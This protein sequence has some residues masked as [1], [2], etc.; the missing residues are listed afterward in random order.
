MLYSTIPE[1]F[2]SVC[3]RF[4][5]EADKVAYASKV[6]GE[7]KQLSHRQLRDAVECLAVGLLDAG[8]KPGDRVGIVSE[9]RPEWVVTDFA[10]T[11]IGVIDVPVFTSLT[12]DQLA[13]IFH[14]C[15]ATAVVVSNNAQAQK[16]LAARSAIPSLKLIIV[17]NAD[18]P[19]EDG[20]V[21]Y[22]DVISRGQAIATVEERR[23]IVQRHV[24]S[25][26]ASDLLT[27][28]Y[29]SG[30]TGH[31]KG[32]ML[33]HENILSNISAA[34][35]VFKIDHH[36]VF[37]SYLPTCHSYER[38]SGYYLAFGCG[39]TTYIAESI[40]TVA[41]NIKE[42]NPTVM[43]SVPRLF[44]RMRLRIEAAIAKES[45]KRR[46][47]A[48]WALR[49]G[50]RRAEGGKGLWG[51][52]KFLLADALVLRKI[53]ARL[54]N[55]FRFFLSG[56]AALR[57]D[58][59]LFFKSIGITILEG[60]GLTESSPVIAVNREGSEKLGTVGQPLPNV[61]V[62]IAADGEILARG[63]NI[64]RGYWRDEEATRD[65]IDEEGWLHTGDIGTID[66]DGYL[67]ITDRKKHIF[68]STGG[69]N[70]APQPVESAIM[71]CRYVHQVVLV[72]DKRLFCAAL[73]VPE[74]DTLEQWA[75]DSEHSHLPWHELI[76]LSAVEE[77]IFQ[78]VKVY[79]RQFSKVEQAR[80]IRLLEE[81][82]TVENGMLTPTLKV[83]RKAVTER[84]AE[85]IESIYADIESRAG[86]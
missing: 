45:P 38:M 85:L 19:L 66:A 40:D 42:A 69:K 64:M 84:Y 83:R 62:T 52:I 71:E 4:A 72:G 48:H 41:E 43:T 23:A 5:N 3:E 27:L 59:G 68:V 74:P 55:R 20:M 1:M 61:E 15:E 2:F 34:V 63:P 53:R 22:A 73:I 18:V 39:C 25:I 32:V 7:W 28:I 8:I 6:A 78:D 14:D 30:T 26:R 13:Y 36:D 76:K 29:T 77:M 17:I 56:G 82:F 50:L 21:Y 10:L 11:S 79:Q 35:S 24:D 31:P 80:K 57:V 65:A 81:P 67:A 12:S 70:I 37:L 54:G 58:D 9:N 33:T 75:V 86:G 16:L 44:E 60:Y 51:R 46:A 49:Q 47:L